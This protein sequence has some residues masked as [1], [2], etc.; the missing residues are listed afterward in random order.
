MCKLLPLF[1]GLSGYVN[2]LNSQIQHD[3]FLLVST[4][5]DGIKFV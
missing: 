3:I 5:L 4:P 2:H 1:P